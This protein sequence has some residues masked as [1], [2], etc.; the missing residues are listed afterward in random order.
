MSVH[1]CTQDSQC[2]VLDWVISIEK[3]ILLDRDAEGTTCITFD[4]YPLRT[5]YVL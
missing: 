3:A 1:L 2:T 5:H 4:G